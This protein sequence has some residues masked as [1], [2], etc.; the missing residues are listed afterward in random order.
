MA[1]TSTTTLSFG[2]TTSARPKGSSISQSKALNLKFNSRVCLGSFNGLKAEA[3]VSCYIK[4]NERFMR[5]K[6]PISQ[7]TIVLAYLKIVVPA[8]RSSSQ[9]LRVDH[10]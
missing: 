2:S 6:R 7:K 3:S 1:A 9:S 10:F 5:L 4:H 8:Y